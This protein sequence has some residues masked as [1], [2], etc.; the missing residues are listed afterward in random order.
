M[1]L[2]FKSEFLASSACFVNTYSPV[3]VSH[4][5]CISPTCPAFSV[6]NPTFNYN[7]TIFLLRAPSWLVVATNWLRL[8]YI[9]PERDSRTSTYHFFDSGTLRNIIQTSAPVFSSFSSVKHFAS[10][11]PAQS[12]SLLSSTSKSVPA[13]APARSDSAKS[14]PGLPYSLMSVWIDTQSSPDTPV[15]EDAG[16][17]VRDPW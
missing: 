2:F 15:W 9:F 5:F 4:C 11:A 3:F 14:L 1:N 10:P 12:R 6:S 7:S 17:A 13:P 16:S 8:N